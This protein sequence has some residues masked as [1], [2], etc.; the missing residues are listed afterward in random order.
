MTPRGRGR[1]VVHRKFI[2]FRVEIAREREGRLAGATV[3][4]A[5][6]TATAI[7]CYPGRTVAWSLSW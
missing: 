4:A 7:V 3:L 2:R 6:T 1:G 5:V